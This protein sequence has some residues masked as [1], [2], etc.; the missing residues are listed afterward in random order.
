MSL[1]VYQTYLASCDLEKLK[2][3]QGVL[4]QIA[5]HRNLD[6]EYYTE[7]KTKIRLVKHHISHALI[8]SWSSQSIENRA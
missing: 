8:N 3:E 1:T 2:W 7:V 5:Y 4:S 6:P